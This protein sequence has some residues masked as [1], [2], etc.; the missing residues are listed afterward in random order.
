MNFLA[1]TYLTKSPNLEQQFSI[2]RL[3]FKSPLGNR[4]YSAAGREVSKSLQ[5]GSP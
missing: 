2:D 4:S 1:L 5:G 3:K